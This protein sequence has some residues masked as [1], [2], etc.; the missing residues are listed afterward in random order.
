MVRKAN[1]EDI[2]QIE[3]TYNEHFQYERE[4]GAFTVFKKN[5]YPTRKDAQK[6]LNSGTL[7]VDERN[8]NIAGSIIVDQVQPEEYKGI[9]WK[10]TANDNK[11][12]VIHLL[13]VRPSMSRKGVASS[14]V[15]YAIELAIANS[16][17]TIRLDTGSQNVPAVSLYKKLG[18]QI[19]AAN[20]MKVGG[21]VA[22]REHL[23]L[24]KILE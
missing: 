11:V 19:V 14:L 23:F 15:Q 6:A 24:E 5:V 18:F 22:H 13:L 1:F 12:M 16:C 9:V 8:N 10:K 7:Y 20:S 2:E 17:E 21:V 3:D 4:H